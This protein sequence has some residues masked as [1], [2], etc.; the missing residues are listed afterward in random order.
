MCIAVCWTFKRFENRDNQT[1]TSNNNK[2]TNACTVEGGGEFVKMKE[3]KNTR[4]NRLPE[5]LQQK[6]ES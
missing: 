4:R 5:E 2:Y 6:H 3:K 1:A